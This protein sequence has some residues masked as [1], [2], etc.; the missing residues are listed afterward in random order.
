VKIETD[1]IVQRADGGS[2]DIENAIPV[3]FD[4]HADIHTYNDQHPK[5]RKFTP[6]EL[7]LHK[8]KWLAICAA[9]KDRPV[10][11]PVATEPGSLQGLL[12]EIE[13]NIY[14]AQQGAKGKL[15]CRI[16]DEQFTKALAA[17][18]ISFLLP[19]TR[20]S[21]FSAYIQGDRANAMG[22]AETLKKSGG[23]SAATVS[24]SARTM[25]S[26]AFKECCSEMQRA[27]FNL[28]QFLDS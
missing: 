12:D 15:G 19:E 14:A 6:H 2:D 21:I 17:G 8:E 23:V 28:L 7:R 4:C 20:A 18:K 5:G 22:N 11:H 24:G 9:S 27:K 3:C 1:H 26:S 10:V 25:P 13:Y 16:R